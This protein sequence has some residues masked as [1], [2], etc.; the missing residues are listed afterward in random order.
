ME[1]QMATNLKNSMGRR[2]WWVTVHRVTNSQKQ[3]TTHTPLYRIK[4]TERKNWP[5][6]WQAQGER[7]NLPYK[8]RDTWNVGLIYCTAAAAKSL[9]SWPTLCDPIDG[10]PPGS[11][12]HGI[13]QA[14]TLE[15]VATSFSTTP[16]LW[17]TPCNWII[18]FFFFFCTRYLG[19][20]KKEGLNCTDFEIWV[21]HSELLNSCHKEYPQVSISLMSVVWRF[22]I[23]KL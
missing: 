15:W 18:V 7:W 4:H 13:L 11:P 23:K 2:A 12:V 8:H 10:S 5:G 9:Q 3:P 19:A 17:D 20:G 22:H 1:E 16:Y 21:R 14:R 6:K